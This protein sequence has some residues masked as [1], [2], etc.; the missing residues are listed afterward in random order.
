MVANPFAAR[1]G[2]IDAGDHRMYK[3]LIKSE[4]Q[5]AAALAR[6]DAL[7]YATAGTPE[8]NELELLA[9]LVV[10]YEE[11]TYAFVAPDAIEA[12]RFRM[13]Q[14]SLRQKDLIPYVGSASRVSEAMSGKRGLTL[15]AAKALH[16]SLGIPVSGLT[17]R[18]GHVI[19][20]W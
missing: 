9:L 11:K 12:I 7:I 17:R 8:A 14:M 16:E 2:G 1:H 19:G 13:E 20:H 15:A 4:Q 18:G 6:L 5:Y 10:E 3:A